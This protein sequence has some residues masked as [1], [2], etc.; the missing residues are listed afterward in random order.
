MNYEQY[1][2]KV[3]GCYIGKSIG[4]SFGTPFEGMKQ[5]IDVSFDRSILDKLVENDDLDL[6]VLFLQGVKTCG[7]HINSYDLAGLFY[8]KY[9]FCPG[10]YAYFKKNFE[11]GVNPP[12]SGSFNNDFYSEGMGCCIRGELWGCLFPANPGLASRY[13]ALDGALDHS[14]ES[15]ISEQFISSVVALAF[16]ENDIRS[17]I[18]KARDSLPE[19]RFK[20]MVTDVTEWC[21]EEND[22]LVIREKIICRYGHP[23]CTNVFQN[24]GIIVMCLL[25]FFDDFILMCEKAVS[26]G[27][28]TDCTAGICASVY[29]V[30]NGAS[31]FKE[32]F[33]FEDVRLVLGIDCDYYGSSVKNF[34]GEVALYGCYFTRINHALAISDMPDVSCT[35]ENKPVFS[36][37]D[38][39]P[40]L[41]LSESTVIKIRVSNM[42]RFT[43]NDITLEVPDGF[44]GDILS[45][46]EDLVSIRCTMKPRTMYKDKNLFKL[47]A[48][49]FIYTFGFYAPQ[50]LLV[51]RPYFENYYTIDSAQYRNGSYY[52]FFNSMEERGNAIRNYHLSYEICPKKEYRDIGEIF[53]GGYSDFCRARNIGDRIEVGNLTQYQG[54]CVLY[55]V[56]EI[57]CEKE[58]TACMIFGA[59]DYLEVWLN[60]ELLLRKEEQG[61]FTFEKYHIPVVKLREG[62]NIFVYKVIRRNKNSEYSAIITEEG[63]LL[64][65]P[66]HILGFEQEW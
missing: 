2:D 63:K 43:A 35:F 25:K 50:T 56:K 14:R 37:E 45:V 54:P 61:Y 34:A 48:G 16:V 44:D 66:K 51:S 27:F 15:V 11:R 26:C 19:S 64:Q 22:H 9:P 33:G 32:L 39:T 53:K 52:D 10:E 31:K 3:T 4:G 23:D 17:I 41:S 8:E 58:R 57:W 60:G 38:Y 49:G 13:A 21:A 1:C 5:I 7:E 42:P 59:S 62:K 55:I 6:Q 47:G 20:R 28:D 18:A 29:G 30:V 65:F 36:L 12:Y 40:V 46:H 24:N